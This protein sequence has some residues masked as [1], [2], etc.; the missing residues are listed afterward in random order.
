MA[1]PTSPKITARRSCAVTGAAIKN[2][3]PKTDPV[4]LRTFAPSA[5]DDPQVQANDYIVTLDHPQCG[6]TK[7]VGIPVQLSETPGSVRS[8]A[9]ELGQHTEE[10]LMD[11]LGWDWDRISALREKGVI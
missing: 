4:S 11:L 1:R 6:P 8:P 2:A 7:M 9:P 3:S 10:I 5:A